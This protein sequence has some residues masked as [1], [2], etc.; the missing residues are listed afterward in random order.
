MLRSDEARSGA[1]TSVQNLERQLAEQV[2]EVQQV[3]DSRSLA[4]QAHSD[5]TDAR[6]AALQVCMTCPHI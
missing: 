3:T 4:A 5:A 2:Q 6:V 1:E